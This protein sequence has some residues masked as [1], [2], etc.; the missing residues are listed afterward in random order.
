MSRYR[1]VPRRLVRRG[2]AVIAVLAAMAIGTEATADPPAPVARHATTAPAAARPGLVHG[3]AW[4]PEQWPEARWPTDLAL[5]KAAGINMVRIGEFAWSRM[6]PREGQ[7]DFGWLERAIAI[8][9]QHDIQVVLGTPTAAPPAWL[10]Q[11]YPDTRAIREDGRSYT[12]GNRAH[13]RASSR[14]Y[15]SFCQRIAGEMAKR[16]GHHPNV[17]GWQ[18]DNEY[19]TVSYDRDTLRGF[20]RWLERKYRTLAALNRRWTT[21]YW[22]QTYDRWDQIPFPIT[23]SHNPGLVLAWKRYVTET[24]RAYQET[25]VRAIRRSADPRQFITHNFMGFFD[26]F[27]HHV[28]A[29]DLDLASWDSYVGSGHLEPAK[30]A[31]AH[32]LTRGFKRKNFWVMETQ[33]GSVN[34]AGVNNAMD[35]GEMRRMAWQAIGHGADAVT[36]WQWRSAL[37]GQEQYHG[38]IVGADGRP[39]PIYQEVKQIGAELAK[40]AE[41]LRGTSVVADVAVLFDYDSRWAIDAQ[42]HHKDFDPVGYLST[43]HR[44]LQAVV[45]A[46]DIVATMAPLGSYKLVVAPALNVLSNAQAEH[47]AAYVRGGGHLVLGARTGMKDHDN[48]LRPERAPGAALSRL[49]GGDVVDFYALDEP[50]RV[51]GRLGSGQATIWGEV[52]EATDRSTEVLLSYGKSKGWLDRKPAVLSRAVGAGRI[53]Y[54]GAQL[55]DAVMRRLVAW[56]VR[57]SRIVPVLAGAPPAV[58]VCRRTAAGRE[59]LILINHG[60]RGRRIKLPG[61]LRDL[62]RDTTRST[63]FLPA[64]EVAVLVDPIRGRGRPR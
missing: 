19:A 49:L 43:F 56:M 32:D 57:E 52:L 53:T 38:T 39:R 13:F 36:Y 18:I 42:R 51:T 64:G 63:L 3:A 24:F 58:E 44:P 9:A 41:E 15:R 22:S 14:R 46:V 11:K 29:K 10:T 31:A 47:L 33:P 60:A 12:H 26:G 30:T 7:F 23:R 16:F 54:V 48:A 17:I 2:S 25:Q 21:A 27:D 45:Q 8:A 61:P 6:E 20:H 5:M 1:Y 55:D 28:M 37:N 4:Y 40:A 34:W 50:V 62:L 35:R 59:V